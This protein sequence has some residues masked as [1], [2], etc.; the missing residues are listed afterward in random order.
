MLPD[1]KRRNQRKQKERGQSLIII[2]LAFVA[3]LGFVGLVT[4][5]GSLYVTYTQLK[6]A[7]D[8]A[9]VAAANNIKYPQDTEMERKERIVLAAREMLAFHNVRDLDSLTV[10]LCSDTGLPPDFDAMCPDTEAGESPRKLAYV[11]ATQESP[12][13]FLRLFGVEAVPFTTSAVGEAATVDL[14]LVFDTSESMGVD[15]LGY[16][17]WDFDPA[18]CNSGNNCQPLRDAK[19]AAKELIKLLFD[20]YDQV[21]IVTFDYNAEVEYGLTSTIGDDDA[22]HDGDAFD[23]INRFVQL[24]DD[25]PSIK[26]PWTNVNPFLQH[27]TFNPIWPE[28]RD[29]DGHDADPAAP[30]EDLPREDPPLSGNWIEP[31]LWDDTT[32]EPCDADGFLDVFDWNGN[33]QHY[34]LDALGNVTG[35][36][37]AIDPIPGTREDTSLLSTCTGC[38][39]RIATE[40]LKAFGRQNSVWVMVFLSDG[41]PNL[42]DFPSVYSGVPSAFTY[43]FCGDNPAT[44]FWKTACIDRNQNYGAMNSVGRYCFDDVAG[45]CPPGTAHTAA[46]GP[47]S[48]EDYAY[49][50]ADAAALLESTN[51]NEPLGEDI[52][53]YTIGLG[54]AAQ[55]GEPVL[56]YMANIG[57]DGERLNDPCA[58][59]A[60]YHPC[61]NYYYAPTASYLN[62][63]FE[64]IAN[65]IFTK[66]SR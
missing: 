9:A 57:D 52:I 60:A 39:I 64:S 48:V 25:A 40:H 6:R 17:P 47:Y 58:S 14:L 56:R 55:A 65:R 51:P 5:V 44:S 18:G 41:V 26:V 29:G 27:K 4:D 12:V 63:I 35:G 20:G 43:G 10:Y 23:A 34:T 53:I 1:K 3:L 49:D 21:G 8:S 50:M 38:G 7:V 31:D 19:D 16:Q 61:G 15:T 24:H 59:T 37:D 28:D 36:D 32:G 33:G 66:I 62:Q 30:C 22:E 13:Y 54:T 45:E 46:S 11:Q 42:S 2:A